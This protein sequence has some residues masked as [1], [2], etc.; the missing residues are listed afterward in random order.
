[1]T[2]DDNE[3]QRKHRVGEAKGFTRGFSG[4]VHAGSKDSRFGS[5]YVTVPNK[6]GGS[7]RSEQQSENDRPAAKLVEDV[8]KKID[9][10]VRRY[11]DI[12]DDWARR[13]SEGDTPGL[14]EIQAAYTRTEHNLLNTWPVR[15]G[16]SELDTLHPSSVAVHNYRAENLRMIDRSF[17]IMNGSYRYLIEKERTDFDFYSALSELNAYIIRNPSMPVHENFLIS[18]FPQLQVTR[19]KLPVLPN[20]PPELY[21]GLRG[22]ETPPAFVA[23]V[24]GEWLGHGL[25]RAHIRKLDSKLSVAIDNWLSRPGNQWPAE[26]DLPTKAEQTSR[27]LDALRSRAPDGR[28]GPALGDFTA[29]EAGRIRSAIQRRTK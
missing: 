12:A 18:L 14:N 21:A 22:P 5:A 6:K 29:R 4:T 20:T 25:T 26:V 9:G 13:L 11:F 23:R 1:M 10:I 19:E 28:I 16:G 3:V 2:D 24:Y 15:R 7:E 17:K 27:D 8:T